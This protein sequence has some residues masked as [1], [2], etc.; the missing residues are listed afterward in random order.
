[1][2]QFRIFNEVHIFLVQKI[3]YVNIFLEKKQQYTTI[4]VIDVKSN[5]YSSYEQLS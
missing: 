4:I 2:G 1:M 3:L 5:F